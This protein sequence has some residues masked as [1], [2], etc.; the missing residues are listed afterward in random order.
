MLATCQNYIDMTGSPSSANTTF[1]G[2]NATEYHTLLQPSE[3]KAQVRYQLTNDTSLIGLNGNASLNEINLYLSSFHNIWIWNLKLVPLQDCFLTPETFPSSWN[4][5]YNT[6]SL[7]TASNIVKPGL[8][9]SRL[10]DCKDGTDNVTFSYKVIRNHQKSLLLHDLGKMCF[11]IFGNYFNG[12]ASRNPTMRFSSFDIFSNVYDYEARNDEPPRFNDAGQAHRRE[13][14]GP[15]PLDA[16]LQ[17]HLD[18]YNQLHMQVK[19]NVFLQYS[20][21]PNNI[22][23]IFTISEATLSNRPAKACVWEMPPCFLST[24]NGVAIASLCQVMADTMDFVRPNV[25]EGP[26]DVLEYVL[27]EVGQVH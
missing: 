22:S 3:W 19:D 10:F 5:L 25:F 13:V 2:R 24:I 4:A 16:V 20:A 1:K 14:L 17:Y 21:F 23:Y 15:T 7:V 8:Q 27:S 26:G 11:T 6:V 9:V 18:V 12:S